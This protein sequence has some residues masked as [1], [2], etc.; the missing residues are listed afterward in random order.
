MARRWSNGRMIDT[1]TGG[2]AFGSG[3]FNPSAPPPA[4]PLPT[5]PF[6]APT[7]PSMPG[8]GSFPGLPGGDPLANFGGRQKWDPYGGMPQIPDYH[9]AFDMNTMGTAKDMDTRLSGINMDPRGMDQFRTEA[10][11]TG[12][13]AWANLATGRRKFF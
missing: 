2:D 1:D 13:S 3:G 12:P 8:G 10:L 6:N 9:P 7:V 11:R 4:G 5:T